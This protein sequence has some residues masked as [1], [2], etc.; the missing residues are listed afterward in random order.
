M[1]ILFDLITPQHF[2]GGAAEYVRRVYYSLLEYIKGKDVNLICIYDS[3]LGKYAYEDLTPQ[4][5]ENSIVDIHNTTLEAIV[6][7]ESIDTLFIGA[8]QYWLGYSLQGINCRVLTVI[9]DLCDEEYK[10]EN[11][12]LFA[13][14]NNPV[15]FIKILLY[16]LINGTKLGK[17]NEL[18][19]ILKYNKIEIVTVSEYSK[20]SILYNYPSVDK[21]FVLYSPFRI[22]KEQNNV[23]NEDLKKIIN[24]KKKFY[25]VLGCNREMKNTTRVINAFSHFSQYHNDVFLVTIGANKKIFPK[26]IPLPYLTETDLVNAYKKCYALIFPSFFEGFG[27]PPIEAM[28]YGKP[29]LASNTT[30]IPEIC[31]DAPLYFSPIYE[32]DIY[33]C[34]TQLSDS[35]YEFYSQ[36]SVKRYK[37]VTRRQEEDLLKLLELIVK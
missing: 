25:L 16:R 9:H 5:I 36:K 26:H 34:L 31:G 17:N 28:K 3:S 11:L 4:L 13:N 12:T 7:Q 20:I 19:N 6:R 24:E 23:Q 35:N 21:L 22:M 1:N 27:Y 8:L 2:V 14:I 32:S 33:R 15:K 30:S 29:I 18:S 37:E 10:R